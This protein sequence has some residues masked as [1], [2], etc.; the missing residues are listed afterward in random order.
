MPQ[1]IKQHFYVTKIEDNKGSFRFTNLLPGE[2]LLRVSFNYKL[3]RNVGIDTGYVQCSFN[4]LCS[5]VGAMAERVS[6]E[7][8]EI[9]K[10]VKIG[11]N[12]ETVNIELSKK[13]IIRK[14]TFG[15]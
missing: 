12:G 14:G 6:T 3:N 13:S 9:V 5:R 2:Y 11:S 15:D 10:E 4:G 8:M 7:G 1:K